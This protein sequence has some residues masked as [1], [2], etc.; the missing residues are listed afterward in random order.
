MS[1][2]PPS[3]S[4]LLQRF[5]LERDETAFS[6]LVQRHL[7]F[8]YSI[9]LRRLNGDVHLARDACQ[10]VFSDL[11]RK[12]RRLVGH[13]VLAG[14]LF[15]SVRYACHTLVR[16]EAR[17]RVREVRAAA[18]FE[19]EPDRSDHVRWE[20]LKPVVD[21]A[22]GDLNAADRD[23]VLLRYF[24]NQT[25]ETIGARLALSPNAARMRVDRA[26]ERLRRSLER[27][28]IAS[29]AAALAVALEGNAL[30][31]APGGLAVAISAQVVGPATLGSSGLLSLLAM[32]KASVG[33]TAAIAATGAF[34][35]VAQQQANADLRAE[36]AS[37]TGFH[38]AP[39]AAPTP[40]GGV[41]SAAP[42]PPEPTTSPTAVDAA[43]VQLEADAARL[44]RRL[45]R[46]EAASAA[47][48]RDTGQVYE[49]RDLDVPPKPTRQ[50]TPVYPKALRQAG[51]AGKA[52]V[53][54]TVNRDGTVR[55]ATSIDTTHPDFA[56]AAVAAIGRW[57]FSPGQR[58][59]VPV[60]VRMRIPV[61]FTINPEKAP[62]QPHDWF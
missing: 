58:D 34:F 27:R 41:T 37:A 17:R 46:V 57:E 55:D 54:F 3:D 40:A 7:D 2:S 60:N 9:A 4:A 53:E 45:A 8:V 43:L 49:L 52:T 51:K 38:A 44:Q 32:N 31:A 12:A 62:I 39:P 30:V 33:L 20:E 48:D 16:T 13:Q 26:L 1:D 61:V 21:D 5:V 42:L 10:L 24:S 18:M 59:Q 11:A 36:I 28:G 15:T 14:W 56:T 50:T 22:L 25:Y 47:G 35:S 19:L 6:E 29:T 23:A